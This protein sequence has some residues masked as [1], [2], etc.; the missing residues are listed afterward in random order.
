MGA[1]YVYDAHDLTAMFCH[2]FAIID[3][4]LLCTID[5]VVLK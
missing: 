3:K 4:F 5:G 2:V 1:V